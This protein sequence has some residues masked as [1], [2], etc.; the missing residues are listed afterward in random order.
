MRYLPTF[1]LILLLSQFSYGQ[2]KIDSLK[3]D[4][5]QSEEKNKAYIY[6]L[7]A[8]EVFY[9]DTYQLIFYS[10]KAD[11]LAEKYKIDSIRINALNLLSYA[12]INTG[13]LN[14]AISYNKKAL[15]ISDSK[16][17]NKEKISSLFFKGYIL[18]ST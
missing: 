4:L 18:Y 13:K 5:N 17:L 1:T 3:Q 12:A 15:G 7:L 9:K 14:D 6:F 11:S 10:K 8:K 2:N 16:H